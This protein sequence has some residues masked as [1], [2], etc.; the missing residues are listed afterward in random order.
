M[1]KRS[2]VV[3]VFCH[4]FVIRHP[5]VVIFPC[6]PRFFVVKKEQEHQQ[7]NEYDISLS[8][9]ETALE[10]LVC[11]RVHSWLINQEKC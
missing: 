6:H 5:C 8:H 3:Q 7:E 2:T 4:S 11:I 10:L 9:V 1:T